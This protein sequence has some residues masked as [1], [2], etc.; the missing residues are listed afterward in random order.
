L[1]SLHAIPSPPSFFLFYLINPYSSNGER[2]N[3]QHQ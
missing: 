2:W 3:L 1:L